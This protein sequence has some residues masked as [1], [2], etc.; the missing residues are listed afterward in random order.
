ME[1]FHPSR[2][3]GGYHDLAR[4]GLALDC[5]LNLIWQNWEGIKHVWEPNGFPF[6]GRPELNDRLISSAER[7]VILIRRRNLLRRFVSNHIARCTGY[8]MGTKAEFQSRL[9]SVQVPSLDSML[10]KRQLRIDQGAIVRQL[11]ILQQVGVRFMSVDYEE[12]FG[13]AILPA[14]RTDLINAVFE[15]LGY[16]AISSEVYLSDWHQ[17]LDPSL[18]RWSSPDVYRQIPN[19]QEIEEEVGS[20][21]TGWLFRDEGSQK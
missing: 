1:P 8:W 6:L 20:D 18:N 14:R 13:S 11:G 15:F 17:L 7:S 3:W 5:A 12:L 16:S 10:V 9:K 2:Y 4:N 19:I 21:E